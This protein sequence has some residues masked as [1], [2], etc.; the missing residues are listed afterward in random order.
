MARISINPMRLEEE[1]EKGARVTAT[2]SHFPTTN[3]SGD[4]AQW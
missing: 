3:G 2:Q 4:V 1:G